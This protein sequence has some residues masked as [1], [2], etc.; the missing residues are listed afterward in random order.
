MNKKVILS[1]QNPSQIHLKKKKNSGEEKKAI[2]VLLSSSGINFEE[3][4]GVYLLWVN[5]AM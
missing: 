5:T 4:C 2:I 3:R 1:I